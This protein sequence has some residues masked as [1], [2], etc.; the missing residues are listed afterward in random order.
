M[1]FKFK[2]K[3]GDGLAE[4]NGSPIEKKL[5][6]VTGNLVTRLELIY[7]PPNIHRMSELG[8]VSPRQ[9]DCDEFMNYI[10]FF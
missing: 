4:G 7:T 5:S 2:V 6:V 3:L 1:T 9:L 8:K 10:F